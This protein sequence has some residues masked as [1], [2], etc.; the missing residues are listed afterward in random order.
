MADELEVLEGLTADIATFKDKSTKQLDKIQKEAADK[1]KALEDKYTIEIKAA[2]EA[3]V[4]AVEKL[5]TE[6]TEKGATIKQLQD[7]VLELKAK[8]GRLIHPGAQDL[9]STVGMLKEEFAKRGA[10]IAEQERKPT[11]KYE[12]QLKDAGN[13]TAAANLTGAVVASYSL[14]P[15]VRG[16]RKLHYRDLVDVVPSETGLWKFYRQNKPPGEGSFLTQSTHGALKSQVD[17]DLT[18]VTITADYL[19]GFVRVAKQMLR[20]LP[21]LQNFLSAEL[22]EDYLRA[23]DFKFFQA[24]IAGATGNTAGITSTVSVERLIQAV[25]SLGEDDYDANGFVVTNAVWAK[26]LNTKPNDYSLPGGSAVTISPNGDVMIV[27]I[28]LFKTNETNIG[29]NRMLIADWTKAKII[30]TDGLSVNMYEQD[31]DNVVRNLITVKA[32]AR[33]GHAMLRPDAFISVA[34]G[35]T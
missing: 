28:P 23:E 12:F 5:N 4:V 25:A 31:Q 33:V 27:G 15:A 1:F 2:G 35:T 8:G 34:A 19:A 29:N 13:M 26:I 7:E 9:V 11:A 32:E 22:V 18:E 30:Q 3:H 20:D 16:R 14:T 6:M 10:E 21:F 24:T 17:Y